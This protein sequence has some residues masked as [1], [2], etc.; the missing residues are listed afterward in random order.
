MTDEKITSLLQPFLA[1]DSL[2]PG[3]LQKVKRYLDLLLKWNAKINLT[4]IRS[5]EGIV[6]RH[7]GESFFAAREL[8]KAAPEATSAVD[9]GSGAGFPGLPIKLWLPEINLTLVESNQKKAAFLREAIRALELD[10]VEV[11]AIRAESIVSKYGLL[12]LRAVEGFDN[13]LPTAFRLL[14]ENAV[15]CLLIG[16]SQVAVAMRLLPGI[17]WNEPVP[18][19]R[20]RERLVLIGRA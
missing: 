7:F 1:P 14:G 12:T 13:V 9:V 2:S 20:S 15:L 10:H 6:T 8:S 5:A 3:Q 18:I 17:S 16:T 4:A 11:K 19:P